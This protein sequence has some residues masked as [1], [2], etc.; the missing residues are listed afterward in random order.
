MEAGTAAAPSTSS[1]PAW[2]QKNAKNMRDVS[3]V[4]ELVDALAAAGDNL[5][6]V[7]FY[8]P[9]CGAC[10]ALHSK[11]VKLMDQ[12][13]DVVFLKVNFE[14]NRPLCKTLGVKVL[15]Y[16]HFYHGA[17]GRVADFSCTVTKLQRMRDALDDFYT[18]ICSL[19]PFQGLSEFPDVVAHPLE[20]ELSKVTHVDGARV[21]GSRVAAAERL[22]ATEPAAVA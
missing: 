9:W 14:D 16:F 19:E 12:Y 11:L 5:V 4:Q 7:D 6:I 13:P 22:T 2:Y 20:M 21:A 17:Q 1:V 18:P 15:P 10:R 3:G 8:A